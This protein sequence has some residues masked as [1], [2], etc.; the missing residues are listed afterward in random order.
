MTSLWKYSSLCALLLLT[1]NLLLHRVAL[2]RRENKPF[3]NSGVTRSLRQRSGPQ[4]PQQE[5]QLVLLWQW[6]TLWQWRVSRAKCGFEIHLRAHLRASDDPAV[7][8]LRT[9][10]EPPQGNRWN[11]W[12]SSSRKEE[13]FGVMLFTL[14]LESDLAFFS[15]KVY[16]L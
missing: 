6:Q 16:F 10:K 2:Y 14:S 13:M 1:I 3:R 11:V 4:W 5:H 9:L 7:N 12:P 8:E 15:F